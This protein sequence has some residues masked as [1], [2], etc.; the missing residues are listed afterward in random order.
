[1]ANDEDPGG[2]AR[3]ARRLAKD[4]LDEPRVLSGGDR[5]LARL[6]RRS[7]VAEIDESVFGARDDLRR[8]DDDVTVAELEARA[9]ERL[10]ELGGEI[11]PCLDDREPRDRDDLEPHAAL[12]PGLHGREASAM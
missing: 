12:S 1:V 8:D 7:D 6:R 10:G 4:Q 5:E 3:D 9:R 2:R 11:D